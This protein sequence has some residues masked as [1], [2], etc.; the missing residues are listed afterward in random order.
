VSPGTALAAA[1]VDRHWR[2]PACRVALDVA[3]GQLAEAIE[4]HQRSCR[5]RPG[6]RGSALE[7]AA[8][9]ATMEPIAK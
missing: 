6:W 7:A 1:R 9:D 2:C 5:G 4:A 3:R 8:L